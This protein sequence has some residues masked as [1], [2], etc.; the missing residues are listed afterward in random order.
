MQNTL[1]KNSFELKLKRDANPI[2]ARADVNLV[3]A[4]TFATS[5]RGGAPSPPT[6]AEDL[7]RGIAP[8]APQLSR[9]DRR[10]FAA[11]EQSRRS[12]WWRDH[13]ETHGFALLRHG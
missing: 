4:S 10:R 12:S 2:V 5:A 1:V 6:C 8:P 9:V 7:R 11:H 3:C 13:A